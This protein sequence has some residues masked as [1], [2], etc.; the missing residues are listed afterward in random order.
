V[1]PVSQAATAPAW[2]WFAAGTCLVC[3]THCLWYVRLAHMR[4]SGKLT[5][6]IV[7]VGATFN[8][9]RLI[10]R[11]AESGEVAVLGV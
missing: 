3:V 8:A 2:V 11:A 1:L 4:Q 7:I 10:E 5:P 9:A 6:N